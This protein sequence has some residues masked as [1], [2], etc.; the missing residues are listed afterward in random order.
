MEANMYL[1]KADL[2]KAIPILETYAQK[3]PT[4]P[5]PRYTLANIYYVLGDTA[6]AKKWADEAYAL[7]ILPDVAAAKPAVK[8]Y[9]AVGDWQHTVRFLADLV[10]EDPSDYNT[11]YDL[12]KVTYLAGDPATAE[13][14]VQKLRAEDPAILPTDQNFLNA[15][16]AYE[17]SKK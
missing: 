1:R 9:L 11:L 8:Y 17:Q 15:I 10:A 7:Y 4:L 5:V 3:E 13:K 12:A 2:R 16:T 14:I 6:T